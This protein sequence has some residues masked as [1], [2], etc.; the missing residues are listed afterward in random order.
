MLLVS[1]LFR[2]RD[3][4]AIPSSDKLPSE[5]QLAVCLRLGLSL[6]F[7]SWI[8]EYECGKTTN[9]NGYHLITCK[10]GGGPVWTHNRMIDRWCDM[11][12][13]L[14]LTFHKEPRD[15]YTNNENRPD[16]VVYDTVDGV[17]S[18]LDISIAHPCS[19]IWSRKVLRNMVL[20]LRKEKLS[21]L[22]LC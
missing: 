21:S 14:R 8:T 12:R 19:N 7:Q 15:R 9:I 6:P 17:S 22:P 10:F 16:I 5:F 13:E 4:A 11:L 18:D 2:V 1:V 3:L 20:L